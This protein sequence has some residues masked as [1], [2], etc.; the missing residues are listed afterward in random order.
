MATTR[1]LV[2]SERRGPLGL[3]YL[4]TYRCHYSPSLL[5]RIFF[6][7]EMYWEEQ[8]YGSGTVWFEYPDLVRCDT[9]TECWLSDVYT[10]LEYER[11]NGPIPTTK[12]TK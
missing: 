3:D 6:L 11:Q 12:E 5:A 7:R 10:R 2:K 4:L 1:K 8:Y 9:L